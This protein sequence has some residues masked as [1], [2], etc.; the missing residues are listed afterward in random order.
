[1]QYYFHNTIRKYMVAVGSLFNDIHVTKTSTASTV[2][3]DI[4]VPI[5]FGN[6]SRLYQNIQSANSNMYDGSTL[7]TF[8]VVLPRIGYIDESPVYDSMRKRN[9]TTR[10]YDDN[11]DFEIG[12]PVPYNFP[13]IVSI[14]TKNKDEMNQIIE[15]ILPN[16]NPDVVLTINDIPELGIKTDVSIQLDSIGY[17]NDSEF[18]QA[19]Y[20]RLLSTDINVTVRGWLYPIITDAKIIELI[21][22]RAKDYVTSSIFETISITEDTTTIS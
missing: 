19:D 8:G 16:F 4:I 7:A 11:Y 2:E 13:F 10:Y 12:E 6:K 15:Q 14:L 17:A 5:E 3:K 1:M 9:N 18:G 20:D 21:T 22:I